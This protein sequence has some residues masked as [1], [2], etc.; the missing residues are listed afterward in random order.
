MASVTKLSQSKTPTFLW[1]F[2][3]FPLD[4]QGTSPFFIMPV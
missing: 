3:I 1:L 2:Y 4:V